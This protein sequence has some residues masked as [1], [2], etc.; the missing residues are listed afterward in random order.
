MPLDRPE[1]L[2]FQKVAVEK[3]W[4]IIKRGESALIIGAAGTG[5]T[6]VYGEL[7]HRILTEGYL[8]QLNPT[9]NP[10]FP[11]FVLTKSP[12]VDQ[13]REVL[14]GEFKLPPSKI[15]VTNYDQ[16][17]STLGGLFISWQKRYTENGTEIEVPIWKSEN[18][19][20]I[21]FPD[22]VQSLKNYTA[23]QTEIMVEYPKIGGQ[24]VMASATPFTKPQESRF[25]VLAIR[26]KVPGYGVIDEFNFQYWINRVSGLTAPNEY[27]AAA[28]ERIK[29]TLE[30]NI[31][32]F[33]GV[34]FKKRT[35][36]HCKLI[37]FESEEDRQDFNSAYADY[38]KELAKIDKEAPGGL[39]LIWTITTKF[40]MRAEE[41]K[42][43]YLAG[44]AKDIAEKQG[45]QIILG[46][47]Y[48][49]PLEIAKE[50]LLALGVPENQIAIIVGGQ[51]KKERQR[52]IK[53]YQSGQALYCLL[54]LK[55]GGVGLSLHHNPKNAIKGKPRYVV[56]PPTWSPIEIVQFLGRGHRINSISTTYQDIV[57]FRGTVEEE[58]A[59]K[60]SKGLTSL[61]SLIAKREIWTD[62]FSRRIE[63]E[64]IEELKK[65]TYDAAQDVDEDGIGE[66]F[67]AEAYE[68]EEEEEVLV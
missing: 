24:V 27:N 34:K 64:N 50:K 52:N 29:D 13:T 46:S 47:N 20:K 57:W 28:M 42:A 8:N 54:T 51:S 61:S 53:L 41:I 33:K 9:R 2:P 45:K 58:V 56:A 12:V 35:F 19:P 17:R 26:P 32:R 43:K 7:I 65:M 37:D 30:S 59:Q 10:T 5:K 3:T 16:L 39:A 31:V 21:C 38:L 1:L 11:I 62:V 49:K 55:S 36:T 60:V 6:Y 14:F 4:P 40:R 68:N 66:E 15:F 22:E 25:A 23:Q 48:V 18:M 67:A 44:I 63:L